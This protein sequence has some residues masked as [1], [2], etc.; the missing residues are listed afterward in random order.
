MKKS[1]ILIVIIFL[2]LTGCN[3]KEDNSKFKVVASNYVAYDFAKNIVKDY[4]DVEL[5]IKAGQDLHSYDPSAKDIIDIKEADLFIY[6]GGESDEWVEKLNLD[7]NKTFIMIDHAI[8]LEEDEKLVELYENHD[9][10]EH[11]H[12]V[13]E[14]VWM[15]PKNAYL[16]SKSLKDKIYELTKNE[17]V[18]K[19]G[20]KFLRDLVTLDKNYQ[21]RLK[22]YAGRTILV[23]DRFPFLYLM[24]EYNLKYIAA[25][26]GCFDETEVNAK[27]FANMI[28]YVKKNNIQYV[29]H[30]DGS[31]KKVSNALVNE[32]N[33]KELLLHSI[34]S[35]T[36]DEIKDNVSYIKLMNQNL[37]NLIQGLN[38]DN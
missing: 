15:S 25:F 35:M 20:D 1:F 3:K 19:Q 37:N 33:T 18:I 22:E 24:K 30:I 32:T 26:P 6:N 29:Y 13:D 9:H 16:I 28:N 38:N 31:S 7:S 36:K 14:H 21:E 12:S 2:M 23:A 4:G 17:N 34:Q 27:H 5:L 8:T 11:D 10:H